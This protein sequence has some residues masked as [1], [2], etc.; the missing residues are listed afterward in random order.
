M[1][2]AILH[3]KEVD[4]WLA[5]RGARV[6]LRRNVEQ[7]SGKRCVLC[8]QNSVSTIIMVYR[9]SVRASVRVCVCVLY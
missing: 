6:I 8:L 7:S 1:T 3:R 2:P 9:P 5:K 4:E